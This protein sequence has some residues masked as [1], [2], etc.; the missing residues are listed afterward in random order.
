MVEPTAKL[1][2][3]YIEDVV[4]GPLGKDNS[5]NDQSDSDK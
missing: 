1:K 4:N 2:Q 5:P 3:M